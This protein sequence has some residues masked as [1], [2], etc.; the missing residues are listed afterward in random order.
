MLANGDASQTA[1]QRN[2][3]NPASPYVS[4]G[5]VPQALRA[6]MKLNDM[7]LVVE[8]YTGC[9][10]PNVRKQLA[11]MLGRQRIYLEDDEVGALLVI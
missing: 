2:E 9:E 3:P 11:F 10:E 7:E 6:A 8:T 4:Q 1:H 5:R